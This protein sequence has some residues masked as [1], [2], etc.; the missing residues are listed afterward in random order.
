VAVV[1][2]VANGGVLPKGTFKTIKAKISKK[3][4]K[5]EVLAEGEN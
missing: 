4:T 2:M 5:R 3:M 1:V